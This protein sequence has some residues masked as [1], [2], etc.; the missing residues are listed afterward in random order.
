MSR[1]TLDSDP[2]MQSFAY[3]AVT[4]YGLPFQVV[5]LGLTK[6]LLVLNPK[7]LSS[8]VWALPR[9]LAAT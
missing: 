3:R 4:C 5:R 7:E 9:S 2:Q 6:L 1:G 8:L